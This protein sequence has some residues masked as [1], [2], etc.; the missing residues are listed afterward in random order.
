MLGLSEIMEGRLLEVIRDARTAQR[1]LDQQSIDLTKSRA[2]ELKRTVQSIEDLENELIE[3]KNE[4]SKERLKIEAERAIAELE[5]IKERYRPGRDHTYTHIGSIGNP[6]LEEI[7]VKL[8]KAYEG[9][10]FVENGE[11]AKQLANFFRRS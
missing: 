7:K 8:E 11:L 4:K 1:D 9:F 2:E 10:D 3:D 5:I 6:G